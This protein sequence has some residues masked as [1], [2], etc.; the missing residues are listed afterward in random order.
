VHKHSGGM[1]ATAE[2]VSVAELVLLL[3]IS[4]VASVLDRVEI[5][6]LLTIGCFA[7]YLL[8]KIRKMDY[9]VASHH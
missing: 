4:Y 5:K 2:L 9:T 3:V 1:S 6:S 7:L 8:H